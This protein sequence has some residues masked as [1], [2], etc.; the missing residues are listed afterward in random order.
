MKALSIPLLFEGELNVHRNPFTIIR[1]NWSKT[2][3]LVRDYD[4][5]S[6]WGTVEWVNALT[7]FLSMECW[8]GFDNV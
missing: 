8:V 3:D 6:L 7:G 1:K 5:D 4:S 2:L